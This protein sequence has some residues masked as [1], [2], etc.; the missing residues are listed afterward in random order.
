MDGK[1]IQIVYTTNTIWNAYRNFDEWSVEDT[2]KL[3]SEGIVYLA[4]DCIYDDNLTLQLFDSLSQVM[5][6]ADSLFVAIDKRMNFEVEKMD[7]VAHGY[8]LFQHIISAE[9][10]FQ[11]DHNNVIRFAGERIENSELP[12]YIWN[13]DRGE[14]LELWKVCI[15]CDH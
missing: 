13:Y 2:N 1:P 5:T 6:H 3:K 8:S 4:A 12:S 15:V 7:L 11:S 14:L 10:S 9:K